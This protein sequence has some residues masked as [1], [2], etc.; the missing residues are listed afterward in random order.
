MVDWEPRDHMS[1]YQYLKF[2]LRMWVTVDTVPDWVKNASDPPP[3]PQLHLDKYVVE[4]FHGD[5]L[6]YKVKTIR[7]GG[8]GFNGTRTEYEVRIK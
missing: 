3:K 1:L 7:T 5:S 8:R 2:K 6:K 4:K